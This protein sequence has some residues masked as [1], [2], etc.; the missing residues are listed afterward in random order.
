MLLF[1]KFATFRSDGIFR[2]MSCDGTR[3]YSSNSGCYV[4]AGRWLVVTG[5]FGGFVSISVSLNLLNK[6]V[7]ALLELCAFMNRYH[8]KAHILPNQLVHTPANRQHQINF[9]LFISS[10]NWN[11]VDYVS[12]KR[13]FPEIVPLAS[14]PS[15]FTRNRAPVEC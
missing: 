5:I 12:V 9:P 15:I 3:V 11:V 6:V 14:V 8:P 1:T 7:G 2:S 10:K 4:C 13:I